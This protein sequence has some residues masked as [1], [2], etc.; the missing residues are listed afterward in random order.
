MD[1]L[2]R[3]PIVLARALADTR[4]VVGHDGVLCLFEP[5]LMSTSCSGDQDGS[6]ATAD[7]PGAKLRP[8]DAVIRNGPLATILKSIQPLRHHL[9]DSAMIYAT[10]SGPGLLLAQLQGAV[11]P[12]VENSEIHPG[13]V[14][15]VVLAAVR[16]SLDQKVDG[17][18][19]IEQSD[20]ELAPELMRC[21]RK[22]RKL[23]DFY[24]AGFVVFNLPGAKEPQPG[25]PAHCIFNLA[26]GANGPDAPLALQQGLSPH[27]LTAP[28]TTNGDVPE[29]TPVEELRKLL[30]KG[31]VA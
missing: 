27:S 14:I 2:L 19:L 13:Y 12:C 31:E 8:A 1:E 29:S 25:V 26:L 23:A 9:P 21:H 24:E 30:Q 22:V 4:T 18:A 15:D 7:R 16:A 6:D 10:F 5:A 20:A 17:I 3:S 28:F 11:E